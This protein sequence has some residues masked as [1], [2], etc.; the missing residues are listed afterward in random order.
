M[1]GSTEH[2]HMVLSKQKKPISFILIVVRFTIVECYVIVCKGL[3]YKL[4]QKKKTG[5][6][7]RH[8]FT[9]KKLI[10]FFR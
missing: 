8:K 4:S 3:I 1:R 5:D 10:F 9:E 7:S 2:E 6:N